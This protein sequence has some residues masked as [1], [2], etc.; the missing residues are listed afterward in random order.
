MIRGELLE[1]AGELRARRVPFVVATVVRV[2]RP[3]S[4]KPGDCALVLPDGTLEGFVGG[5]CSEST[6]RTQGLRQLTTG[7]STL[8]RI[9]P[10]G[11]A[12]SG[13]EAPG[14]VTVPNPCLSGGTLDIFLEVM[15]PPMLVHVFGETPVARALAEVGRGAG[16]DVQP[17]DDPHVPV[18]A[19]AGA[20]VVASQG[21]DEVAVLAAALKSGVPYV[22]LVASRKRGAS[23]AES[24]ELDEA[25][26][27][28]FHTPAG[29]D[30][31]AHTPAEIAISILAEIISVK[32][33]AD[34]FGEPEQPEMAIDPVCGMTVVVGPGTPRSADRYFCSPACCDSFAADP[35]RYAHPRG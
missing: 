20:V 8:L 9:Q 5:A 22:G 3:A 10:Q 2:E 30:I 35:E 18:A 34:A 4:A 7:D 19:D 16:W 13:G 11:V 15:R 21:G 28:R 27:E 23:V 31:G 1:R 29:L 12:I 33:A 17:T 25:Q 6:V 26:R 14:I 32:D 24:L